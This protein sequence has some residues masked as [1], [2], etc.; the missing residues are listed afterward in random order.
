M[1][2][3]D[4]G[5]KDE[6]ELEQ[7][8]FSLGRPTFGK[9]NQLTVIG[10]KGKSGANKYYV[11]R[12]SECAKDP[13]LFGDGI[14]KINKGHLCRGSIP[15]NCSSHYT[16]ID[17]HQYSVRITREC[18]VRNLV[19]HGFIGDFLGVKTRVKLECQKHGIWETSNIYINSRLGVGVLSVE[20][21]TLQNVLENLMRF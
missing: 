7:D 2:F 11:V 14:F 21:I 10:W 3:S 17:A 20:V 15:C 4:F 5:I 18:K 8:E 12:C 19:F 6:S 9:E 13:E 1:N 16:N